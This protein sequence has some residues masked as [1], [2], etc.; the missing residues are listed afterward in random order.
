MPDISGSTV[1]VTGG[2]GLIGSHTV[3]ALVKEEVK[4]NSSC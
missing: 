1:L 2:S 4:K 3:D